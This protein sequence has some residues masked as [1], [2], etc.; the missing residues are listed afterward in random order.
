MTLGPQILGHT[1]LNWAL[2]YVEASIVSGTIL[3]EPVVS[4]A[5]AW[6][7]LFE[8]PG[9][10]TMLGGIIVLAGLFLLLRGYRTHWEKSEPPVEPGG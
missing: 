5:L 6:L 8:R 1:V 3:A 10:S 4:A 9:M 2:R 7:I